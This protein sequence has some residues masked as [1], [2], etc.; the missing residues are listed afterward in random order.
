MA[1][2]DR[3]R[4]GAVRT[5]GEQPYG[6]VLLRGGGA[7]GRRRWGCGAA[8]PSVAL[9]QA[10]EGGAKRTRRLGSLGPAAF[11]LVICIGVM[12]TALVGGSGGTRAGDHGRHL[13]GLSDAT[14]GTARDCAAV[15]AAA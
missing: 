1:E 7:A 4:S 11:Y 5:I 2:A 3:D 12:Q 13:C 8:P 6:R 9:G 15:R 10:T 14:A